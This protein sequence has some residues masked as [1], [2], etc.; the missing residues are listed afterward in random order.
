MNI[1]NEFFN[2]RAMM[3]VMTAFCAA[4]GG[5]AGQ[6]GD[7]PDLTWGDSLQTYAAAL[8][9]A[10]DFLPPGSTVISI[11]EAVSGSEVR[12]EVLAQAQVTFGHSDLRLGRRK[13]HF[14][15]ERG[16]CSLVAGVDNFVE[17]A[18]FEVVAADRI[19]VFLRLSRR[20][21][22]EGDADGAEH[23][24]RILEM[25]PTEDGGWVVVR[26]RREAIT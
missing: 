20:L 26:M 12:S 18:R 3:A 17:V 2:A 1:R 5:L 11:P 15:C 24:G 8:S 21:R 13:D 9:H 14:D 7:A 22:N 23:R 4:P 6:H 10:A 16:D 19:D 25:A